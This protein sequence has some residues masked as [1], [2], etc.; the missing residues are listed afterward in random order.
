MAGTKEGELGA[1]SVAVA[2]GAVDVKE[3]V[4]GQPTGQ[5]RLLLWVRSSRLP[6]GLVGC[7]KVG[8]KGA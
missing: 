8:L 1:Y 2:I 3:F 7:G 4:V 5:A 6:K